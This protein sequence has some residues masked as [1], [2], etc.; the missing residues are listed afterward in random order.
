MP[1]NPDLRAKWIAA[2]RSGEYRQARGGLIDDTGAR[3]CL[4]VAC[5]VAGVPDDEVKARNT[6]INLDIFRAGF[7][8]ELGLDLVKLN[9]LAFRNDNGLTFAEI[10]DM[11]EAQAFT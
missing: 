5:A 8:V 11:L 4:G 3:C 1:N 10:A 6:F 9:I 2:L 7:Q